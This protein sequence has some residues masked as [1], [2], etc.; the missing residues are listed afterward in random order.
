MINSHESHSSDDLNSCNTKCNHSLR[1][2]PFLCAICGAEIQKNELLYPASY[3]SDE[4]LQ[5]SEIAYKQQEIKNKELE[6]NNKMI[7]ILDL[8]QTIIHTSLTKV[9]YNLK[10]SLNHITYYTKYRPYL[11]SFLKKINKLF[12]IHVY[13]MGSRE[14][15]DKV[16]QGIDPGNFFF[17]GRIVS[18][19][20]NFN[21]LTKKISRISCIHDNVIIL[22]DRI[23]VWNNIPNLILVRPFYYYN[24]ID[25]NDPYFIKQSIQSE[26]KGTTNNTILIDSFKEKE[27]YIETKRLLSLKKAGDNEHMKIKNAD[28]LSLYKNKESD[29]K[30]KNKKFR[31]YSSKER[32]NNKDTEL[33]RIYKLLKKT[34]RYF[35]KK[36]KRFKIF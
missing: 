21:E 15:A 34:H 11:K 5:T 9:P 24:N 23:D 35:F 19:N 28:E 7:L 12:E 33:I 22:D 14:Y 32:I 36:K 29:Y 17:G 16:C 6:K 8:D 31:L 18:R 20:E 2:G 10:F 25:I 13:T 3:T 27:S 4:I 26:K 1:L 30:Y